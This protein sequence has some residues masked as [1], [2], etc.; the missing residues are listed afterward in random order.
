MIRLK[1]GGEEVPARFEA[2]RTKEEKLLFRRDAE[3]ERLE[4]DRKLLIEDKRPPED[5]PKRR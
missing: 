2:G 3:R 5:E 4:H 1:I